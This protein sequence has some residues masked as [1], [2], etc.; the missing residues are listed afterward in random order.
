[1]YVNVYK[2][3]Y[4]C[5]HIHTYTYINKYIYVYIE[6][7]IYE[8][9]TDWMTPCPVSHVEHTSRISLKNTNIHTRT[10]SNLGLVER[11]GVG[12][13]RHRCNV[14]ALLQ[15]KNLVRTI[16]AHSMRTLDGK[17]KSHTSSNQ[18]T[19]WQSQRL[20]KWP[21]GPMASCH[22]LWQLTCG[23]PRWTDPD[24][25]LGT[26][27]AVYARPVDWNANRATFPENNY[28]VSVVDWSLNQRIWAQ[29][30]L[31]NLYS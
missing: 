24:V 30:T 14:C 7:Y 23:V 21:S 27:C 4:S 8:S 29:W 1:M 25:H 15:Q 20:A 12:S 31:V 6:I 5:T 2:Y 18:T 10:R 28:I 16:I 17:I 11:M 22:V 3:K 26:I 19:A 9:L 13:L